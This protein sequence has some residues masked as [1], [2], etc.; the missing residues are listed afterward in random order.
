MY[1]YALLHKEKGLLPPEHS[2]NTRV[3]IVLSPI[4]LFCRTFFLLLILF[5]IKGVSG[6]VEN[7]Q[8]GNA[9]LMIPD[10]FVRRVI[11]KGESL[12]VICSAD[13]VC[14]RLFMKVNRVDE[15]HIRPGRTVLVPVDARKAELYLPVPRTL[16]DSRGEREM[17]IFLVLQY[18]GAYE[19]G[20]L[21]FWGP[22]S[23]GI[24]KRATPPGRFF[25]QYKERFKRSTK[26]EN[27]PMPFSINYYKGYFVHQQS[28]PGYAASHGCVRLL[29]GDAERLFFWLQIRDPVTLVSE[30]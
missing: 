5:P 7:A 16:A 3:K 4:T 15:R 1:R 25:V 23:S 11:K 30:P 18:F 8:D 10:G 12:S 26:Y 28:L 19:K 17:R 24:K 14:E 21:L 27:A 22:L 29:G 2:I 20:E 9:S 13:S 6:E